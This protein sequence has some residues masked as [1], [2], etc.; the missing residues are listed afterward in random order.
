[1]T[2]RRRVLISLAAGLVLAGGM[3]ANDPVGA[4]ERRVGDPA[5]S[6]KVLRDTPATANELARARAQNS[7]QLAEDPTDPRFVAL[8]HRV[9]A[10]DFDCSLQISG[11][12]GRSW[13]PANPVPRLPPGAE[14][15]YAPEIA[16]DRDG[17]LHYL[18]IG[19]AGR[20]NT[21]TGVFLTTSEDRGRT[22]GEPRRLLG[23]N[24][25]QARM[26]ID[27]TAG[28][29]GRLHLVWLAPTENAPAGGLPASPNPILA[30]YSDDGGETFSKPV[31]VSDPDRELSVAPALAVGPDH[32]VHVLYYDLQDDRRDYQ[33]LEGPTWPGRWSLV[34]TTSLD[35]GGRFGRGVVVDDRLKPPERVML[36][37]TMPPPALAAGPSGKVFA[38]WYD[39]RNGDWDAFVG[40]SSDGGRSWER[41]R[42]LSDDRV[43]NGRHQYLP[44][45]SVAPGGRV[46]AIF[47]DRRDDPGNV[48]NHTY[49]TYSTDAGGD[50][51]PNVRLTS[52]SSSSDHGQR[53]SLPSAE[54]LKDFGSR[55]GLLSRDSRA[56]AAWTDTRNAFGERIFATTTQDVYTTAAVFPG[57]EDASASSSPRPGDEGPSL[58][59]PLIAALVAGLLLGAVAV[60]V[61]IRRTRRAR[62]GSEEAA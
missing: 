10:P 2:L 54:G 23:P 18:F 57:V 35:G 8:A 17:V 30:S 19:L 49:Y 51:A 7:A 27:R 29:R 11:D 5:Q 34:S 43:G 36:I 39:A 40:R 46:D 52:T 1:M 55:L 9:D 42:R 62:L 12:A 3:S 53:Y 59:G 32:A 48:R 47:L 4:G 61:L 44:R 33:G 20:G 26:A 28:E 16:F 15:C 37:F 38:A 13:V 31:Q 50:F 22:F 60:S 45:L 24:N 58:G 21:P 41:P 6:A 25:Y 56:L 14:K